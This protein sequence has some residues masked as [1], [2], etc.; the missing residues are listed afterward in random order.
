[1]INRVYSF[2]G[3]AQKA[4]KLASG[5]EPC[6]KSIRYMKACAVVI[7]QDAS[8]NTAKKFTDA[9]RYRDIPFRLYGEKEQLG[10]CIGK[11]TRSVIAVED[12]GF[13]RRLLEMVDQEAAESGGEING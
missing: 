6:E 12:S 3:L 10:H 1:M 11:N 2:L 5:D 8:D 4:G 7:A 9:C 13:A